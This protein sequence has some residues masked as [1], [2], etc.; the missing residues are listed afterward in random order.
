MSNKV[1]DFLEF[2]YDM[3]LAS[4]ERIH[5]AECLAAHELI[6]ELERDLDIAN[7]K[8]DL[9]YKRAERFRKAAS[10]P[11]MSQKDLYGIKDELGRLKVEYESM[12]KEN[13]MLDVHNNELIIELEENGSFA[14]S[15]KA[16][17]KV[18]EKLQEEL[19]D[20]GIRHIEDTRYITRLND[21]IKQFQGDIKNLRTTLQYDYAYVNQMKI[22]YKKM[23]AENDIL[24]DRC[25]HLQQVLQL[26]G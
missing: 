21:D 7:T 17:I 14:L 1:D 16:L 22:P 24:K 20:F 11:C 8:T 4:I 6:R 3:R 9:E 5:A 15:N 19:T 18:N 23:K 2:E 26:C 12:C 25:T 10:I 13:A